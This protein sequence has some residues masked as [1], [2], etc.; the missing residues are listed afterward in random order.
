MATIH[1]S[2]NGR[3]DP[4]QLPH[5]LLSTFTAPIPLEN[6]QPRVENSKSSASRVLTEPSAS[7]PATEEYTEMV[8]TTTS[9]PFFTGCLADLGLGSREG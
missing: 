6:D 1:V 2:N 5:D 7:T 3:A 8:A 9:V 4:D